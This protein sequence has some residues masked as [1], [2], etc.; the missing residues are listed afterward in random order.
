[1]TKG[2]IWRGRDKLTSYQFIALYVEDTTQDSI[3]IV[4]LASGFLLSLCILCIDIKTMH[5]VVLGLRFRV[6]CEVIET[7]A[8]F[9]RV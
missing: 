7:V 6:V 1:M 3:S 4:S 9:F 5:A 2:E 8:G